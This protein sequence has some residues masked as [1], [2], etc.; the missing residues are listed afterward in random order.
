MGSSHWFTSSRQ[1]TSEWSRSLR[2]EEQRPDETSLGFNGNFTCYLAE[3]NT[4][5]IR[6]TALAIQQF[7][8]NCVQL[9]FQYATPIGLENLGW[10]YFIIHVPWI[11][12]EF[13]VVFMFFPETKGYALEEVAVLFGEYEDRL[14]RI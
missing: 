11:M 10:K 9:I 6:T 14:V 1:R 3:I 2:P 4:F 13:A 7:T 5:H 8:T 12:I